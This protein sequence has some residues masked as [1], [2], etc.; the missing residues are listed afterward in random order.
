[1]NAAQ[2]IG[3]IFPEDTHINLS[4]AAMATSSKNKENG[5]KLIEFLT[6]AIVVIFTVM[7]IIIIIGTT[8]AWLISAYDFPFRKF[9]RWALILPLD[10]PPYI[11]AYTILIW[12]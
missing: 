12:N 8:L 6:S 9:L 2:N 10:I 1:M 4:F 7:F 5:I 3:L 11:A